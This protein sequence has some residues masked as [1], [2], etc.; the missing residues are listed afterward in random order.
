MNRFRDI[1]QKKN[2]WK[3][4]TLLFGH[5]Y[6]NKHD[7]NLAILLSEMT[8]NGD[9]PTPIGVLYKEDKDTYDSMMTAQ[10]STAKEQ[11]GDEN[12]EDILNSGHTWKVS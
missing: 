8:Y 4:V 6:N 12:I 5:P 2:Y 11:K 3:K 1:G 9:L 7:K 10:I